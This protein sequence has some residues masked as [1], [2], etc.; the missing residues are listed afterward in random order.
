MRWQ[1]Q[2]DP[3]LCV[4]V[5]ERALV[6]VCVRVCVI[7]PL[8]RLMAPHHHPHHHH[9]HYYPPPSPSLFLFSLCHQPLSP[10]LSVTLAMPIRL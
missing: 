5:C 3:H 4:C 7:L 8:F 10:P 6:C 2:I 1:A 9:H